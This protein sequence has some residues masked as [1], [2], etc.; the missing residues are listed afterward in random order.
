MKVTE[1]IKSLEEMPGNAEVGVRRGENEWID[2]IDVRRGDCWRQETHIILTDNPYKDSG[3]VQCLWVPCPAPDPGG[4]S[5]AVNMA[6]I[7]PE[8]LVNPSLVLK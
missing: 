2:A 3:W 1:L 4:N 8:H 7:R 6:N 5:L